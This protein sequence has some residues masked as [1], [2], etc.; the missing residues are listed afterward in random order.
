V[1]ERVLHETLPGGAQVLR[2]PHRHALPEAEVTAFFHARGIAATRWSNAP[3]T[4]YEEHAHAYRKML[5]CVEGGITFFLP[6]QD[7]DVRLAPGDR[8]TLPPGVRHRALVGEHGVTCIEG[9]LS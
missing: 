7:R 6:E 2:W 9:G 8:L 3:G 1:D 5:F 4:V